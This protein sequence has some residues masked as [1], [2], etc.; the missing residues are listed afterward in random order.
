MEGHVR[1]FEALGGVPTQMIRYDSLTAAVIRVVLVRAASRLGSS[2][3]SRSVDGRP[4]PSPSHPDGLSCGP[5]ARE[6]V[7]YTHLTLPTN[8]EV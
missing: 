6:P 7:S 1:A 3:G 8:R 2:R 4:A 5:G